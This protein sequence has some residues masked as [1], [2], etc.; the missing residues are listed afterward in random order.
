MPE[1]RRRRV[2]GGTYFFTVNL[3]DREGSDL[4]DHV[5]LLRSA[6]AATR[7]EHPFRTDAIVILPEHL[8]AVWTVPPGDSDYSTRWKKIKTRF[9][10]ALAPRPRGSASKCAKGEKGLWQRRFW[11]HTIRDARDFARHVEYCWINPLK[12]GHV[13]RVADW[14]YSSFHRDVRTGIVAAHWATVPPDGDYGE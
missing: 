4:L 12:H 5:G 1:Y 8:H 10:R 11:E 7:L 3:A 2:P 9:T 6:Y 14:P 13:A